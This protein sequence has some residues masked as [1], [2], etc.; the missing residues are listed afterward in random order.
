M[1]PDGQPEQKAPLN[2]QDAALL[3]QSI[4]EKWKPMRDEGGENRGCLDCP[5]CGEY[6]KIL[7]SK[8]C[9]DCPIRAYTGEI[10]CQATPC[11]DY[12]LHQESKHPDDNRGR[13]VLGCKECE[14]L[15]QKEIEFLGEVREW[16]SSGRKEIK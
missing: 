12:G 3:N 9:E 2:E 6:R 7:G 1:Y 14:T 11:H 15:C 16:V 8:P 4:K 10:W 5:L 13:L